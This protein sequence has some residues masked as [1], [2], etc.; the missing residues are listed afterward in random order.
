[1]LH[2]IILREPSDSAAVVAVTLYLIDYW[3]LAGHH[4][5]EARP[6]RASTESVLI[7]RP[8][9][10][11]PSKMLLKRQVQQLWW[12]HHHHHQPVLNRFSPAVVVVV[13]I[14]AESVEGTV[15]VVGDERVPLPGSEWT[16]S[17][18][19]GPVTAGAVRGSAQVDREP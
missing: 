1:M 19:C 14:A 2:D 5:L 17:E 3:V 4:S 8:V 15:V 18:P 6:L 11:R 12:G 13:V 9:L 10:N 7:A 16:D